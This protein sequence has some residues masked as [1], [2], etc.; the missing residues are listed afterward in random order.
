MAT[1][2]LSAKDLILGRKHAPKPQVRPP[3]TTCFA[4]E[5][6]LTPQRV[7]ALQDLNIAPASWTCVKCSESVTAPR[8]GIFMGEVGTSELKIVD[9]IYNDSVRDIFMEQTAAESEE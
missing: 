7:T 6:K 5:H 1:T 9:R 8:L 3:P 2:K 4:C